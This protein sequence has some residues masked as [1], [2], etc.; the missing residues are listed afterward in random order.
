MI[1]NATNVSVTINNVKVDIS[2]DKLIE[3]EVTKRLEQERQKVRKELPTIPAVNTCIRNNGN[4]YRTLLYAQLI[5]SSAPAQ[6]VFVVTRTSSYAKDLLRKLSD[7]A[8]IAFYPV[9]EVSGKYFQ[10]VNGSRICFI[11]RDM[12]K[13]ESYFL[14]LKNVTTLFDE[15]YYI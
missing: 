2:I 11:S 7:M 9:G 10:F 15:S 13:D 14:G 8:N 4:T 3:E 6:N 12:L 5:A 1:K